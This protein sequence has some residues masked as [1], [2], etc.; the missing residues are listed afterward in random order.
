MS[1]LHS[2]RNSFEHFKLR[3]TYYFL[4]SEFQFYYTEK[5]VYDTKTKMSIDAFGL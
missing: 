4:F 3:I 1:C 5:D 2:N